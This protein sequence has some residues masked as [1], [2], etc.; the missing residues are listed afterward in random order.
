M[1]KPVLTLAVAA[2]ALL[3]ADAAPAAATKTAVFAG[4]C[5]WS[6]EKALEHMPGVISAVSGFAGGTK[7]NPTYYGGHAGYLEAVKVTYDPAKISYAKLVDGY[8]HH[9]DP[10]DPNG[11]FCD[12]GESYRT[13]IFVGDAAER[14]TATAAKAQVA[15]V[16]RKPVATE[17]RAA[18]RFWPGPAEHQDFAE[19]NPARYNAYRIGCGRD[20]A[21]NAV[22]AGR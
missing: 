18:A 8:F 20:A 3:A 5:Y 14:A 7:P 21:L 19:R 12:Q 13:A 1:K 9:I 16:L 2:F 4:G 6:M 22:W 15:K 10:T 11:Q 17:I